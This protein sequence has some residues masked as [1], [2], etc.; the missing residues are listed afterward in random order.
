MSLLNEK[1]LKNYEDN[2]FIA[3]IDILNL[4]ETEEIKKE[5]E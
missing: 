1:Q 4:E 5:I 3:P 2:G